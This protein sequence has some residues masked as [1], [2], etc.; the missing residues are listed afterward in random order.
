MDLRE[1]ACIPS[2]EVSESLSPSAWS[3]YSRRH[4]PIINGLTSLFPRTLNGSA[5]FLRSTREANKE[6]WSFLMVLDRMQPCCRWPCLVVLR[7][8]APACMLH[9]RSG[10]L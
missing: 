10:K 3:F 9:E 6:E 5:C 1:G 2:Y 4:H 8:L 7:R